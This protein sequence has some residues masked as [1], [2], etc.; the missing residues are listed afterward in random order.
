[1]DFIIDTHGIKPNDGQN[2]GKQQTR[3]AEDEAN[4]RTMHVFP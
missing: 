2:A 1:M 4:S 3:N